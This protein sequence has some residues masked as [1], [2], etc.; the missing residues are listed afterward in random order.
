MRDDFLDR[1]NA[2]QQAAEERLAENF[3]S[4]RPLVQ[5]IGRYIL[6]SSGKRLRPIL[7]LLAVELCGRRDKRDELHSAIF[8]MVHSASLL[9][10][11]VIDEAATRRGR[12]A[13]NQKWDNRAVI[14]AGDHLFA[15]AFALCAETGN[16][17][18][19]RVMAECTAH[20]AEGQVLELEYQSNLETPYQVYLEIITAK[21]AV[22][23]A[24][25]ARIGAI[26]AGVPAAKEEA[27]HCFGKDLGIAFQ[28]IDDLLDWAGDEDVVGK[29]VGQDLREGK[30]TLPWIHAL[31]QAPEAT[32]QRMLK[33]ASGAISDKDFAWLRQSVEELGGL[34]AARNEA[35]SF[36]EKARAHLDIFE[37]SPSRQLILD[38]ADYVCRRRF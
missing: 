9:H 15:R 10:D 8:E 18:V 30:A 4:S 34:E 28:I 12:P 20:L 29:P 23:L 27:L 14:L 31:A 25:T 13:A 3:H 21:T 6:A 22:L 26:M 5:E 33:T 19:I 1:I 32:R 24:A 38:L 35:E 37:D 36:K 2:W 16:I 7:Y 17:E 11:D